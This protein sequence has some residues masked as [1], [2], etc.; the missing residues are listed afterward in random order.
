MHTGTCLNFS[1]AKGY[2][3][4]SR[5]EG[6]PDVFCHFS[7]IQIEGYKKLIAGQRVSFNIE[8]G[9]K[10][11]PQACNV[12]VIEEEGNNGR[13]STSVRKNQ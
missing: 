3:F 8:T 11:K 2:G 9:P 1:A 13:T 6:G 7:A 10:G 5:D 12:Y 4:L